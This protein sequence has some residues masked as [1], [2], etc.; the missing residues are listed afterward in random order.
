[1][2]DPHGGEGVL[3]RGIWW[4]WEWLTP[5]GGG[6]VG[7]WSLGGGGVVGF[8][9]KWWGEETR[10]SFDPWNM[11]EETQHGGREGLNPKL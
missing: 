9:G 7:P 5:T 6:G 4:G 3:T 8:H 1:M 2:V 10:L 11:G